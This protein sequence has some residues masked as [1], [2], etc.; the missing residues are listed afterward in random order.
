M[1]LQPVSVYLCPSGPVK[2]MLTS[3]PHN[4]NT[5]EI[6]NNEVPYTAHYYGVMGPKGT[7][8]VTGLAY[9]WQNVG[10]HGGMA[11]EGIFMRDTVNPNPNDGPDRGLPM[12][13]VL[14]GTSTTL[15]VGE[16]SWTDTVTGTRYRS[17]VRGCDSAPVCAG[18]RNVV[19]AI[20]SPS[21]AT[22]NDI[23]F[24]SQH[25]G[26]ANFIMVDGAVRFINEDIQLGLYRSLAS[27]AGREPVANF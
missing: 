13:D 22:F 25:P 9:A 5:G 12:S 1:A 18:C 3:T 17:W 19:N 11:S 10:P 21:V 15:L 24:G 7:N 23:A 6:V 20:N 27:C 4:V 26:G 14:D 8:P 16:I 2:K